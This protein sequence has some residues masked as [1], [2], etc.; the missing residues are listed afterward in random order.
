MGAPSKAPHESV[1]NAVRSQRQLQPQQE[2]NDTRDSADK[3]RVTGF[4]WTAPGPGH[5]VPVP[6]MQ[7][8]P[9]VKRGWKPR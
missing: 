5:D 2:I 4:K 6:P 1:K 3:Q 9:L 8:R 7:A